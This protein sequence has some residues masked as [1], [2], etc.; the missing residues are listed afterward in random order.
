MVKLGIH[1]VNSKGQKA[2][3]GNKVNL[4]LLVQGWMTDDYYKITEI[5]PD[6]CVVLNNCICQNICGIR[7]FKIIK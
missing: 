1:I 2:F 4:D 3:V 7:D 5:R 6:G